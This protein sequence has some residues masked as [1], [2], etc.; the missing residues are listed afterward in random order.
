MRN[1]FKKFLE[2]CILAERSPKKLTQ[3]VCVGTWIAFSPFWG[4]HTLLIFLSSWLFRLNFTVVFATGYL[5][6]NPWTMFPI[7]GLDYLFGYYLFDHGLNL[8]LIQYN[9]PFMGW[10]NQKIGPY[11]TKFIGM[12]E[13]SFWTFIIGGVLLATVVAILLYPIL[14]P[15]F[16]RVT[17]AYHKD[18]E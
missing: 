10:F 14:H 8:Q 5:V 12:P 3:A 9:P 1:Y 18:G 6:N 2:K 16:L 17:R 7:F 15:F 13:L 11:I 4:L